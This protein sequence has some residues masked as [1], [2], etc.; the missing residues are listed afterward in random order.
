[1]AEL[2]PALTMSFLSRIFGPAPSPVAALPA[3]AH[4]HLAS[5]YAQQSKT[6]ENARGGTRRE[7]LRV[8]LRDTLARHGIPTSWMAAEVLLSTSRAGRRGVHWRLV[9]KHWDERLMAHSISL[10]HRLI[11]RVLAVDPLASDWLTGI[12]WQL[13]LSDEASC[14][15]MP[16]PEAW[17]VEP[18]K[19]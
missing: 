3:A 14:P 9:V 10:Q 8:V 19:V 6:A 17:A 7:L 1:M 15:P 12:S 11:E 18:A 2:L 16:A 13:E 5:G 4:S